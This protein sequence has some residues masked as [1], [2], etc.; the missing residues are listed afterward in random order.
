MPGGFELNSEV[1]KSSNCTLC[2][3]CLDW[4]PY[5]K[6]LE[7]HLAIPFECNKSDGRCYAVCPRTMTDWEQIRQANF[8]EKSIGIEVGPILEVFKVKRKTGLKDQQNG[9]TVTTLIESAI[10]SKP[11]TA[12]ILT[13]NSEGAIP[14]PTLVREI[15]TVAKMAG[16]RFL[17][18]PSLRKIVEASQKGI[19]RLVVVGRPCQIQG[20][21]KAQYNYPEFFPGEIITIGLFCMWSLNWDFR[22]YVQ[23]N[24]P[25]TTINSIDIPQH[26]VEIHTDQGVI[27][28]PN[29]KVRD[30]IRPA[31]NYC[32]DMTSEWADISVGAFEVDPAW[33]TVIVRTQA[34]KELLDL[35]SEA[36]LLLE[37][38]PDEEL[39]R[40]KKASFNKK[41]RNLKNLQ[42][43]VDNQG[44]K[45]FIDLSQSPYVEI[46]S[47]QEVEVDV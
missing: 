44:L 7:D 30:F 13:G 19:Q 34:G 17:A 26:G 18:S 38:F 28:I 8:E 16:S 11:E 36:E 33:N 40:L 6:N 41:R 22:N 4:C 46:L 43:A 32:L 12:A 2:G 23:E 47:S 35:A 42:S 14:L 20:I 31:C 39:A 27:C 25:G 21:R 1:L 9:G 29:E 10:R 37:D 24:Y 45:P 5:I 15:E 3:L